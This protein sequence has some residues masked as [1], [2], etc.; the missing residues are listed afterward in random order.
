MILNNFKNYIQ[1]SKTLFGYELV[2]PTFLIIGAQKC[3]TTALHKFLST[4]PQLLRPKIKE[5]D[6]FS[7][8]IRFER[9]LNY[10]HKHFY[11]KKSSSESNQYSFE[12]SPSYF[13]RPNA[14]QRIYNYN[15]EMK[16]IGIVRDPVERAFSAWNMYR[17]RVLNG[18]RNF[19]NSWMK[20]C[21]GKNYKKTD[22]KK[23]DALDFEFFYEAI[24]SEI[25]CMEKNK[26]IEMPLLN[27][28]LYGKGLKSFLKHFPKSQIYVLENK[29]LLSN[30]I[31]TLN[32]L[33]HFLSLKDHEWNFEDG[34][35]VFET[36]YSR[37]IDDKSLE[38]LSSFYKEPNEYFFKLIDKEFD[39]KRF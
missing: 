2:K 1:R 11:F 27:S 5:I 32:D 30:T 8:D 15:P 37:E 19:F 23:R 4:H 38:L 9:G 21:L 25:K 22:Y 12:A 33:T 35:R 10:Y 36:N 13:S 20:R 16:L 26:K 34:T 29:E 31:N 28:G 7:C 39:W 3:G 6:Y 18:K 24:R 14:A 17:N